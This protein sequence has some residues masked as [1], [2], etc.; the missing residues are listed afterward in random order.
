[1]SDIEILRAYLAE[2][3]YD[4]D[5]WRD[6]WMIEGGKKVLNPAGKAELERFVAEHYKESHATEPQK[7]S[8]K[9]TEG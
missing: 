6:Y 3:P 5:D 4:A 2:H 9:I 1:M 8:N 7:T